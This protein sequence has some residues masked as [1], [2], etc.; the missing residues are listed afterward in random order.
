MKHKTQGRPKKTEDRSLSEKIITGYTVKA[1]LIN[2]EQAIEKAKLTKGLFILATNQ[3][4]KKA[5]PDEEILLTYKEQSGTESG[6]K[7]IKDDAFEVDSIFLKK[8][9]RISALMMMTLC[10]MVYG[11]AQYSLRAQLKKHADTL[12][13]QTEK[14]T[15]QPTMKWIYRLFHGVH[16]LKIQYS[17]T[18]KALILN[19]NELLKK[20]IVYFGEVACR[21]YNVEYV[22]TSV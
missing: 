7:F 21:V 6:F 2:D 18:I 8:P 14:A 11:F 22:L 9:G 13:S 12:P 3:L 10:L 1:V 15:N 16:A 20:I 17:G 4:N 19:V 5:L